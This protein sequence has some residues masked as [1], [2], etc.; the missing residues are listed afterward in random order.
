MYQRIGYLNRDLE[1]ID[2]KIE[3]FETLKSL[4]DDRDDLQ[5]DIEDLKERIDILEDRR[6]S[7]RKK[8]YNSI[9]KNTAYFLKQDL[10]REPQ[11]ANPDSISFDFG[12]DT[13]K[14]NQRANY[15]ASSMVFLKNA[16][17]LALLKSSLE[18][19][20]FRYPR[21]CLLDNIEDKGMTPERSQ[22]FQKVIVNMSEETNTS[23]QIIFTT[24][25]IDPD[26]NESDHVVGDF[27]TQDNKTLNL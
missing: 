26:L 4:R 24:S 23:H 12:K 10:P 21:F 11:F 25:V 20:Y 2:Q 16:F 27:Y 1:D 6:E 18:E 13:V 19:E 15:A 3:L 5:S 14:V 9:R 17:H 8:A 22:N 7:R